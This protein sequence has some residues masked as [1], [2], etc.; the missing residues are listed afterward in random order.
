MPVAVLSTSRRITTLGL[1]AAVG[2]SLFV[3]EAL[4]PL[5]V[6]FL[7]IGLA[8]IST[9]LALMLFDVPAALLVVG[10]RVVIGSL[11][12]G[13]LF[14]PAFL[15]AIG[16]GLASA[17]AMGLARTAGRSA[18]SPLGLSVIGSV[19]HVA[20]QFVL[21]SMVFIESLALSYLFPLLL[22]SALA[23][24]LVVGWFSAR[25]LRAIEPLGYVARGDDAGHGLT[26]GSRETGA[27]A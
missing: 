18:F 20:V 9:L 2:V 10:L 26:D 12:T 25:I 24:G 1:L 22:G 8:N 6:P 3:I 7:K 17:A 27:A 5:P 19:T 23:G 4:I 16:G 21:V 15:L 13:S 11:L 14:S